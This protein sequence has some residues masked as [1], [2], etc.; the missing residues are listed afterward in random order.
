MTFLCYKGVYIS[1][2]KG[3]VEFLHSKKV[4]RVKWLTTTLRPPLRPLI[5]VY[6]V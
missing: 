6:T 1:I 5:K 4:V 2:Y 3:S